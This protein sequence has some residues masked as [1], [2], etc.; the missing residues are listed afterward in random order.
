M[1]K[2]DGTGPMGRESKDRGCVG[3]GQGSGYRR[4]LGKKSTKDLVLKTKKEL[5]KEEKELLERKLDVISK[6]LEKL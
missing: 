6:Q 3:L 5:L 2:G 1:P 4:G